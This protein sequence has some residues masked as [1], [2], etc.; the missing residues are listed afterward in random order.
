[1][2]QEVIIWVRMPSLT[3]HM[4]AAWNS[5]NNLPKEAVR[6]YH[7]SSEWNDPE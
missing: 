4:V 1:M 2:T 7:T 6:S 3:L 5:N